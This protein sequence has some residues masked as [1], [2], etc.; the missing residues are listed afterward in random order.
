MPR[1]AYA[2]AGLSTGCGSRSSE[3]PWVIETIAPAVKI[4]KA[5]MRLQ[6]NDARP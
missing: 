3:T 2:M 4:P 5:A 1:T 6:T